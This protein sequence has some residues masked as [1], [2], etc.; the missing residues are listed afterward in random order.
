[1]PGDRWPR[2]VWTGLPVRSYL[3]IIASPGRRV[4]GTGRMGA[5]EPAGP[6]VGLGLPFANGW[7]LP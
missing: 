4:K 7:S 3:V 1:M 2:T 6:E 5:G